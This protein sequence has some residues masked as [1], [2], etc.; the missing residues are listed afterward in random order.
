LPRAQHRPH[1]R[2]PLHALALAHAGAVDA[3]L[4][5]SWALLADAAHRI[6]A[7]PADLAGAAQLT[8][9]RARAAVEQVATDV[10]ARTGRALGAAPLALD[11]EHARRVADLELYLRQSHAERDLEQLGGLALGSGAAPWDAAP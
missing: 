10:I 6:D 4:A 2:R 8:A 11:G 3:G 1:A 9:G 7:A 5:S